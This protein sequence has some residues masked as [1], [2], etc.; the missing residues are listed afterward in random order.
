[1]SKYYD[2]LLDKTCRIT[3]A[4]KYIT[5]E[6]EMI[7]I[8]ENK[9]QYL[10][11]ESLTIDKALK[12][13]ILKLEKNSFGNARLNYNARFHEKLL[14][15]FLEKN[16]VVKHKISKKKQKKISDLESL[17]FELFTKLGLVT[18]TTLS[19]ANMDNLQATVDK[20]KQKLKL[21]T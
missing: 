18:D 19:Q 12:E 13:K 14:W 3:K 4:F 21:N 16:I 15:R 5:A 17:Q 20:I 8:E 1:M 6:L 10:L 7:T 11:T 2:L 9:I